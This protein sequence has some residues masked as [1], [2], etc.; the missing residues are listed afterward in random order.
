MTAWLGGGALGVIGLLAGA[1]LALWWRSKVNK[2]EGENKLLALR[3]TAQGQE[4]EDQIAAALRAE[5]ARED[6]EARNEIR[7]QQ[8]KTQLEDVRRRSYS[9]LSTADL[10][11]LAN[12][13]Q[14]EL[15]E[16]DDPSRAPA[17]SGPVHNR[18][19]TDII[20]GDLE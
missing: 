17:S 8:L 12:S 16:A 4:L 7:I 1:V 20:E 10:V 5:E 15:P 3:L 14:E 11:A 9:K 6:T 19:Q 18:T 2:L 13:L